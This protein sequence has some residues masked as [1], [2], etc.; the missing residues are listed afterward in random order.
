MSPY[1]SSKTTVFFLHTPKTAGRTLIDYLRSVYGPE[2]SYFSAG[3]YDL[4]RFSAMP[5]DNVRD[6]RIIGGHFNFGFHEPHFSDFT[7]FT[8]LREPV[9]RIVSFYY[10]RRRSPQENDYREINEKKISLEQYVLSGMA[11][12]TDN[13]MVRRISGAGMTPPFGECTEKML[14][15]AKNNVENYF[16]VVG[17]Q[18]MFPETLSLLRRTFGWHDAPYRDCNITPDRPACDTL[19]A[20][21]VQLIEKY[22]SLDQE[23]YLWARERFLHSF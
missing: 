20:Q 19:T 21:T 12:E 23:L 18:E 9:D 6:L 2:R 14:E 11:K 22:N 4:V 8:L 5:P 1:T 3:L 10:Y 16:A 7:Y 17:L 13:G 15:Q